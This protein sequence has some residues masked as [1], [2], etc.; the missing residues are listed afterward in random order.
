MV[1]PDVLASSR[2]ATQLLRLHDT[3]LRLDAK[4][5]RHGGLSGVSLDRRSDLRILIGRRPSAA[6]RRHARKG[7]LATRISPGGPAATS[8]GRIQG[9]T[10]DRSDPRRRGSGPRVPPAAGSRQASR[11]AAP[12]FPHHRHGCLYATAGDAARPPTSVLSSPQRAEMPTGVPG[13]R[14]DDCQ[15]FG[16]LVDLPTEDGGIER[17]KCTWIRAIEHRLSTRPIMPPILP[18]APRSALLGPHSTAALRCV[19]GLADA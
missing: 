12:R 6:V 18:R 8:A 10:G 17:S 15:V 3:Q 1:G 5:V 19:G 7:P 2:T 11:S 4:A 16:F 14:T 9:R 13:F